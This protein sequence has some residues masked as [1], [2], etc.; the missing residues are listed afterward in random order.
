[1]TRPRAGGPRNRG[2]N[3]GGSKGDLSPPNRPDRLPVQLVQT[4]L[5]PAEIRINV[6]AVI[7]LL[8]VLTQKMAPSH[9]V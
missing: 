6:Q 4:A 8:Y 2:S 3:P 5:S 9:S 7:F 1:M